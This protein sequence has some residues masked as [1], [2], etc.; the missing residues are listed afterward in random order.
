YQ[1]ARKNLSYFGRVNYDYKERYLASFTARRDGSYA[2]G[3]DNKFANFFSGSLGWIVTA[4]DFFKPSFVDFLKIRG[5]YGSIGNENVVPQ[6][7]RITTGGPDYGSPVN[8]NGYNFDN[9]FYPGS[10][11]G[12]LDNTALAW[13]KQLQLNIGFDI[14]LFNNKISLSA[15][16]YTRDIKGLLFGSRGS[17]YLGTIPTPTANIGST[18]T[19][20]VD[21]TLTYN[22]NINKDFKMSNAFTFTTS[23]NLVT[24]TNDDGSARVLGGSYFNGQS[25]TVTVF[26]KGFTPAYFYGYKTNGLF[27]T[28]EEIA[29][30][31]TQTGAQPG[32]IRFVDINGDGVIT[33]AD[34]TKIG[35]PYPSFTMGWNLS[36]SFKNFD[37]TAFTYASIG[38]DIYRAYE[39]NQNFTN[40]D[41]SV[42]GRWTGPGT[43]NDAKT[44]R[45]SF[46]DAN[47]NIRVSD[48]YV[49]DGTF[50]KVKNLQLGYTFPASLI[51]VFKGL[52][53]YGQV[54]NAFVFTKYTGFDPEIQ[55]G[56]GLL[57]TG[58]DR[59]TYPQ[60]RVYSLGLDI[61]L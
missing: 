23:K 32:D 53:I 10:T 19:K 48:R 51:K 49:E 33:A 57:E 5:S 15:D 26:E 55:N 3:I 45:Y 29:N 56:A 40:K 54:R 8:S 17:D 60:P 61:K 25:Q 37:F 20:G 52:R 2:F 6:Y 59:G 35:D 34:Q 11:L 24:A 22:E 18:E 4:E 36:L 16:Y 1:G 39:R 42:L 27:Q 7:R 12:S 58:V 50:V 21:I 43:T 13:E 44:P 41:R 14:T 28:P 30:A 46:T 31:P 38:N 9:I 47:S